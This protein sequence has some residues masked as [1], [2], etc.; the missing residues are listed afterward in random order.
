MK[1]FLAFLAGILCSAMPV[2][3]LLFMA[4]YFE[5]GRKNGPKDVL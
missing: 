2:L 3:V 5:K 4:G 1:D